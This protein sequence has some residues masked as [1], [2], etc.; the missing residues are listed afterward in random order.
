MPG[1]I[2]ALSVEEMYSELGIEKN[3]PHTRRQM[4]GDDTARL[5]ELSGE[6]ES[7]R[8]EKKKAREASRAAESSRAAASAGLEPL[9]CKPGAA[10]KIVCGVAPLP[11]ASPLPPVLDGAKKGATPRGGG[12]ANGASAAERHKSRALDEAALGAGAGKVDSEGIEAVSTVDG[13]AGK[14]RRVTA[15]RYVDCYLNGGKFDPPARSLMEEVD[16]QRARE[17][18]YRNVSMF[19]ASFVGKARSPLGKIGD[20]FRHRLEPLSVATIALYRKENRRRPLD[21]DEP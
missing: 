6:R 4:L 11:P 17:S 21:V 14:W 3:A 8:Q 10:G 7:Q 15:E 5:I 12:K 18:G 20:R 13:Q 16:R 1:G 19:E 9:R 2:K